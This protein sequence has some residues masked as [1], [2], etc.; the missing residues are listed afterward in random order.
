M[1]RFQNTKCL[2]SNVKLITKSK[3]WTLNFFCLV[4]QNAEREAIFRNERDAERVAIYFSLV[5]W[6]FFFTGLAL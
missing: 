2:S 4:H 1:G 6:T 5:I 3:I